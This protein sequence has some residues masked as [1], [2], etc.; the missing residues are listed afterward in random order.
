MPKPSPEMSPSKEE[1]ERLTKKHIARYIQMR[2]AA[3]RGEDG[4]N[5]SEC[6][7]LLE[8]WRSIERKGFEL[9]KLEIDEQY[10]LHDAIEAGE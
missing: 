6:E 10:E 2:D 1:I 8:I 5:L 7:Q 9:T 4:Y 3:K